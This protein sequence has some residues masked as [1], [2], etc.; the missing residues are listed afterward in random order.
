MLP[1]ACRTAGPW[2]CIPL[3]GFGNLV[4]SLH[5]GVAVD[6]RLHGYRPMA[7]HAV[8]QPVAT[9]A[10]V[11]HGVMPLS[12]AGSRTACATAAQWVKR[13]CIEVVG[14]TSPGNLAF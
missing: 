9:T 2:V 10:D 3:W 12:L 6:W 1:R 8:L 14:L 13:P 11:P 5:A 7:S 4:Q